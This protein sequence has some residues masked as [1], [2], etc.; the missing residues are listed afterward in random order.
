M[1]WSK[2]L[3]IPLLLNIFE[4]KTM[5]YE[6]NGGMKRDREKTAYVGINKNIA[7]GRVDIIKNVNQSRT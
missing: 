1:Q 3:S 7:N 4:S 5:S 6:L 2:S